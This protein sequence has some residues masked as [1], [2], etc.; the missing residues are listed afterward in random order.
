MKKLIFLFLGIFILSLN[1]MAGDFIGAG[2]TELNKLNLANLDYDDVIY[3]D[4][5]SLEKYTDAI[6]AKNYIDA[7]ITELENHDCGKDKKCQKEKQKLIAA[8]K[9]NKAHL[10][11]LIGDSTTPATIPKDKNFKTNLISTIE[12]GVTPDDIDLENDILKSFPGCLKNK[13]ASKECQKSLVAAIKARIAGKD[14]KVQKATV[15]GSNNCDTGD[16]ILKGANILKGSLTN[17]ACVA[18][19]AAV[20]K[21]KKGLA[22]GEDGKLTED[23]MKLVKLCAM[24][25]AGGT[26]SI[27]NHLTA[28][29]AEA[30]MANNTILKKGAEEVIEI[31]TSRYPEGNGIPNYFPNSAYPPSLTGNPSGSVSTGDVGNATNRGSGMVRNDGEKY[32]R[33]I[34]SSSSYKEATSNISKYTTLETLGRKG[35]RGGSSNQASLARGGRG[36]S[37]DDTIGDT[38]VQFKKVEGSSALIAMKSNV[39]QAIKELNKKIF[40]FC[41]KNANQNTVASILNRNADIRAKSLKDKNECYRLQTEKSILLGDMATV[42]AAIKCARYKNRNCQDITLSMDQEQVREI[43]FNNI[44]PKELE[45]LLNKFYLV[46]S[47]SKSKVPIVK[48]NS[49]DSLLKFKEKKYKINSWQDI[50]K[51]RID[52]KKYMKTEYLK[53]L[54]IAKAK[55]KAALKQKLPKFKKVPSAMLLAAQLNYVETLEKK[56]REAIKSI[57][58]AFAKNKTT[59]L[60]L[61]AQNKKEEYKKLEQELNELKKLK[62]IMQRAYRVTKKAKPTYKKLLD[63]IVS[64]RKNYDNYWLL[65]K[66][67]LGSK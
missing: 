59:L 53:T 35:N 46:A 44:I 49:I 12:N 67:L 4:N 22:V 11:H 1:L 32:N 27:C 31:P 48:R 64:F 37:G 66:K 40:E 24:C 51:A 50:I 6:I 26:D 58:R 56:S 20:G 63:N 15:S 7:T 17:A 62:P 47:T 54:R 9:Y 34:G 39:D 42:N 55:A 52:Y 57:D 60:K 5:K 43:S 38:G 25:N 30:L 18:A 10:E 36:D 29:A 33:V 41:Y 65:R 28:Q 19:A 21:E 61:K 45:L 14:V 23:S 8:G 16:S 2:A 13:F 3:N